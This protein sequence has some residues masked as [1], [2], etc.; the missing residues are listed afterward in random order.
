[1]GPFRT[2]FVYT[3]ERAVFYKLQDAVRPRASDQG[4]S[5]CLARAHTL[6]G[7]DELKDSKSRHR[8][9]RGRGVTMAGNPSARFIARSVVPDVIGRRAP[10][11]SSCRQRR[12]L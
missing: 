4:V 10:R 2:G 6:T 8:R 11:V 7:I 12:L 1:M 9:S 5:T 3:F